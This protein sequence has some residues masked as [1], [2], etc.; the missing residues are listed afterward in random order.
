MQ[1]SITW[2]SRLAVGLVYSQ[3]LVMTVFVALYSSE[4]STVIPRFF[5]DFP[6]IV[7]WFSIEHAILAEWIQG[8][9]GLDD[10]TGKSF[11]F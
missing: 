11:A 1:V 8:D 9:W 6:L 7:C 3:S 4:L 5:D 10:R 2:Q